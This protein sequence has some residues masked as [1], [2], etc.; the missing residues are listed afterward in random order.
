M[1]QIVNVN[2]LLGKL[3]E[4]NMNVSELA[5]RIGMHP[6]A[7]YRRLDGG[8]EKMF[9]KEANLIV[10][11]LGLSTDEAMRIFFANFVA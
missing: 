10:Q 8:C 2:L 7:L 5:N 1:G 11:E 3:K 9:M 4:R 6:A